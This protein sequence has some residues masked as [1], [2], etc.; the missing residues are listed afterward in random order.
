[1]AP[2]RSEK[3]Y[4]RRRLLDRAA[5][6]ARGRSRR[7]RRK[8][9][10]LYR[11]VLTA[12][13][14]NPDLLRK[15]A[16]LLAQTDEAAD[17]CASYRRAA[18]EFV[19]RGFVDRAVG[20]Y[21]DAVRALPHEASMWKEM[22]ALELQR[23]RSADAVA[24]L[25]EGRRGFRKRRQREDALALL[26]AARKIDPEHYALNMD[27]A[28]LLARCGAGGRGVALLE[29]LIRAHPDR[30]ARVRARHF[31][32]APSP[33]AAW[34]WMRSAL[35]QRGALQTGTRGRSSG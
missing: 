19:E 2:F 21:R 8:A 24:A 7:K 12:E 23:G 10:A 14:D 4:D 1:M 31:R 9:V 33:G 26:W 29:G 35:H 30:E 20:V 18:S 22:A 3:S 15:L 11:R 34:R 25:L 28:S 16:P 17:A 6:A 13:P 32:I 27:L 5:R